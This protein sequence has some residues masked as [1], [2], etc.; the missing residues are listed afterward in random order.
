MPN[1]NPCP[2]CKHTFSEPTKYEKKLFCPHCHIQLFVESTHKIQNKNTPKLSFQ[3]EIIHALSNSFLWALLAI[4]IYYLLEKF[5]LLQVINENFNKSMMIFLL[6]AFVFIAWDI[7]KSTK[8]AKHSKSYTKGVDTLS[9]YQNDGCEYKIIRDE[10]VHKLR[11]NQ[12]QSYRMVDLFWFKRIL[13]KTEK[14]IAN[15][16]VAEENFVGCLKCHT[17]YEIQTT[18]NNKKE[19]TLYLLAFTFPII[20]F[21]IYQIIFKQFLQIETYKNLSAYFFYVWAYVFLHRLIKINTK[22]KISLRKT[23]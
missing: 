16:D 2:E 17:R 15:I 14:S 10:P 8:M 6:F 5:G 23:L 9:D 3:K 12:C 20:L 21:F 22:G 1:S 18:N 7:F 19:L 11:C 4:P 13:S